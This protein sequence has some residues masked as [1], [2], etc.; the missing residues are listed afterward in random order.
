M[1]ERNSDK[2]MLQI[3]QWEIVSYLIGRDAS[4]RETEL[5]VGLAKNYRNN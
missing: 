3:I 4:R 5:I 2:Q 1:R